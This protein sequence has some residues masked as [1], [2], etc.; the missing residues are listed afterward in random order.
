[1]DIDASDPQV[2]LSFYKR[3]YPFKQIF[4]WLNHNQG[5]YIVYSEANVLILVLP[6]TVQPIHSPRVLIHAHRRRLSSLSLIQ[7]SGRLES[8][9]SQTESDAFRDRSHI[10]R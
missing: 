6:S 7:Q 1:M 2:T 9:Y 4:Q 10:Y 8:E 3:L 5:D